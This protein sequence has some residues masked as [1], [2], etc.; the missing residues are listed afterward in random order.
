MQFQ[1]PCTLIIS[2]SPDICLHPEA[3]GTGEDNL[4][5]VLL[6]VK[7]SSLYRCAQATGKPLLQGELCFP[8][9]PVMLWI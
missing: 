5:A 1:F 2:S 4:S 3:A 6:Y 9:G 7:G 8:L